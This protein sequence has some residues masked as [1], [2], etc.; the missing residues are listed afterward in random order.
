MVLETLFAYDV[1]AKQTILGVHRH[2]LDGNI[3]KYI[4]RRGTIL[5]KRM[6]HSVVSF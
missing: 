4:R 3:N 1:Y 2:K 6:H 5:R